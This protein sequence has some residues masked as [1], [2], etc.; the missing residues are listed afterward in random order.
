[1]LVIVAMYPTFK[2]TTS[3]NKLVTDSPGIA[4]LFGISGSLTDPVGWLNANIYANFLPLVL[5]LLS[6][7]FGSMAIAG[8]EERGT[9]G[10][11]QVLPIARSRVVLEKIG[12]MVAQVA[13]VGAVTFV[14]C[15]IG[16]N[17]EVHVSIANLAWTTVTA[18]LLAVDFGLVAMAVGAVTG[19]RSHALAIAG[20]I[21]AALYLVASLA[22]VVSAFNTIRWISPW[23]WSV[24]NGQ[25]AHGVSVADVVVLVVIGVVV[26]VGAIVAYERH[27]LH[28]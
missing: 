18:V 25:L 14:F 2:N 16:R 28:G 26:G 15:V 21:T 22:P 17:F 20:A 11:V 19:E 3:L 5:L 8:Q 24:S 7:G 12:A 10:F 27:D 13:I 6:I 1:V 4:A 9:L 23:Y